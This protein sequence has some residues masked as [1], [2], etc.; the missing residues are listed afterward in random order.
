MLKNWKEDDDKIYII[1][2]KDQYQVNLVKPL[3]EN[4]NV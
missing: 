2:N 1:N 4:H 3:N